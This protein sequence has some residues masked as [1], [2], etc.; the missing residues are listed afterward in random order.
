MSHRHLPQR[1]LQQIRELVARRQPV[2]VRLVS[3]GHLAEI[4]SVVT[5]VVE[6][7]AL[8]TPRLAIH[9]F[10]HVP[11]LD[12]HQHRVQLERTLAGL[13]LPA[14]R[15]RLVRSRHHPLLALAVQQLLAVERHG[16]VV[17]LVDELVELALLEIPL[18]ERLGQVREVGVRDDTRPF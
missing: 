9:L 18:V 4:E 7:V 3:R 5:R 6:E 17:D 11:R 13:G 2:Q 10:P 15:R 16:V 1:V 14:T 8:D 12:V